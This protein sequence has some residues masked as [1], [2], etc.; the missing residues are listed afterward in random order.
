MVIGT[1]VAGRNDHDLKDQ[2]GFYLNML[3]LRIRANEAE[4]YT[5]LLLKT[6]QITL[7]AFKHQDYPFDQLSN[8]LGIKRDKSRS[9]IF[10]VEIDLHN[11]IDTHQGTTG[12]DGLTVHQLPQ[13]MKG[14]GKFDLDFIFSNNADISLILHYNTDLFKPSDITA[15][16]E[17]LVA[18]F[19]K[20]SATPALLLNDVYSY[21]STL[22]TLRRNQESDR[23]R[24][25]RARKLSQLK[26]VQ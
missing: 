14:G 1:P 16:T 2:V 5:D 20:T 26:H 6:R 10:D 4:T 17:N 9:P 19:E 21:L 25:A 7:A 12:F 11:F 18:V 23:L 8:A 24:E 15:L 13:Q 22:E 3:P